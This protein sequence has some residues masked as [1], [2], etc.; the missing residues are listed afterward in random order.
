MLTMLNMPLVLFKIDS[1]DTDLKDWPGV[2]ADTG[3]TSVSED[4]QRSVAHHDSVWPLG[5]APL[6]ADS[7]LETLALGHVPDADWS[8]VDGFGH[9]VPR[10][11]IRIE[12]TR[13]C[14]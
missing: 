9:H 1:K 10:D 7:G 14:G 2:V 4:D 12:E 13:I 8:V 5:E 11:K 3:E 6:Y